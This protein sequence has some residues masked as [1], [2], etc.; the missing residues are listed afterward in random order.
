VDHIE[1][2]IEAAAET[3]V[4][5]AVAYVK[6]HPNYGPIVAALGEKAIQA[7]AQGL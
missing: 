5:D 2:V 1:K 3:V 6:A 4:A 7:L